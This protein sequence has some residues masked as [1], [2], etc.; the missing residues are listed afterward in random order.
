MGSV[1]SSEMSLQCYQFIRR[2]VAKEGKF[3]D[4]RFHDVVDKDSSLL[5]YD[6]VFLGD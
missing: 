2:N 4:I 1:Y 6:A 3:C 5:G